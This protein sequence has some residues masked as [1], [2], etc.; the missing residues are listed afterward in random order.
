MR[1]LIAAIVALQ[2]VAGV[3]LGLEGAGKL[4][5]GV[6]AIAAAVERQ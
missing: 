6:Y 5:D 3:I 2:I 4:V 1:L